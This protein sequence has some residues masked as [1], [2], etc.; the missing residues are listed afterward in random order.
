MEHDYR[1]YKVVK[2]I[3]TIMK[4]DPEFV[5]LT[6]NPDKIDKF[7]KAGIKLKTV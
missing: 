4:I 5:L 1:Q 7:Q 3:L 6:N 2:D